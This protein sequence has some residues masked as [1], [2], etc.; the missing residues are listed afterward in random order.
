MGVL[1][2]KMISLLNIEYLHEKWVQLD[3]EIMFVR[4]SMMIVTYIMEMELA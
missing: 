3:N 1:L 2:T 4:M